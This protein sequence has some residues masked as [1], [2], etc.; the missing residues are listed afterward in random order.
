VATNAVKARAF[1]DTDERTDWNHA[2]IDSLTK[3]MVAVLR[4]V[5][6]IGA[7]KRIAM[8]DLRALVE[9]LGCR[10]VRTLLNSGNVV[11][12]APADWR[13][14]PSARIEKALAS[15]F[16]VKCQVTVLSHNDVVRV[17]HDNPFAGVA[18]NPSD[19]L[20]IVPR[21]AADLVK[22]EPLLEKRWGH[23]ALTLGKRVAYV[24]CAKSV[25]ESVLWP[26]VDR[27]LERSGTA[28]NMGTMTKLLAALEAS[29]K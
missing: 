10:D 22:L 11:F 8:A 5:N 15:K 9:G 6:N 13:G 14:D 4:G 21:A 29:S 3:R 1:S 20:V 27:A 28:R 25:A 19:L 17:V 16:G 23:E 18:D 12:S 7:T 2:E 26:A 24:W